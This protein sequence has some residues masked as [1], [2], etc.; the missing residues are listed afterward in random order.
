MGQLPA[1]IPVSLLVCSLAAPLL[2]RRQRSA[3][4]V[5]IGAVSASTV[6]SALALVRVLDGGTLR[7]DLGGWA[8]PVGIEYVVD[9]VAAFV[10]L[11]VTSVSLLVILSTRRWAFREAG[12][13]VGVFYGLVLLL[14]AGTDRD[15]G[16]G[17]SVQPLRV[18]R[19]LLPRR[20]CAGLHRR[21]PRDGR[22][23]PLPHHRLDRRARCTCSASAS[24]TS[25]R[26]R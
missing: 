13:R 12:E 8:P 14:L 26:A 6:A 1:A 19:D 11:V 2:G 10:S 4:A 20:L 22:R 9:E 18:P 24:S 23:V 5:A 17:R 16:H 3:F 7:Y 15:R 25:R 21:T